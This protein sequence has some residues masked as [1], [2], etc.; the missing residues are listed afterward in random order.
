MTGV[1][2]IDDRET[3]D[4]F[5]AAMAPGGTAETFSFITRLLDLRPQYGDDT[6]TIDFTVKSFMLNL[7]GTL[8]G[9]LVAVIF[10]TCMGRLIRHT[11]GQ[12]KTV[13]LKIQYLRGIP[14]GPATCKARLLKRGRTISFVEAHLFGA[15]GKM[16]AASTS[17]WAHQEG[18]RREDN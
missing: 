16:L 10:D 15:D 12:G 11:V 7:Q 9:G 14:P 6:C 4:A 2:R 8:H 3:R 17:T 13:E 18:A 1:S 5:E